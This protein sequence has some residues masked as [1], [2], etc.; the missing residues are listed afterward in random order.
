MSWQ[1][2]SK[3]LP[4]A[5]YS[6]TVGGRLASLPKGGMRGRGGKVY[7]MKYPLLVNEDKTPS[8]PVEV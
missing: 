8:V 7:Y 3:I 6:P 4:Q 5:T 1:P 2:K